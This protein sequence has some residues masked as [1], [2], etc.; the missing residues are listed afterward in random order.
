MQRI[1]LYILFCFTVLQTQGQQQIFQ[2][3]YSDFYFDDF[4]RLPDG[5]FLISGYQSNGPYQTIPLLMKVD[6]IGN[7][8][9][10]KDY[11]DTVTFNFIVDLIAANNNE[12]VMLISVANSYYAG[13]YIFSMRLVKVDSSGNVILRNKFSSTFGINFSKVIQ[14]ENNNFILIGAANKPIGNGADFLIVKLDSNFN[15]LW[16]KQIA[17]KYQSYMLNGCVLSDS[18]YIFQCYAYD[19]IPTPTRSDIVIAKTDTAGNVLWLKQSGNYQTGSGNGI[20]TV[21][22]DSDLL[23]QNGEIFNAFCPNWF[24][25]NFGTDIIIQKIDLNGNEISAHQ[26]GNDWWGSE[27]LKSFALDNNSD[28]IFSTSQLFIKTDNSLNLKWIKRS[29][30]TQQQ[31]ASYNSTIASNGYYI[32]ISNYST[33]SNSFS[34]LI[35]TDTS[36][37]IGCNNLPPIPVGSFFEQPINIG[38]FDVSN[39]ISII[40]ATI[41][42]S[43]YPVLPIT[44]PF[45]SDTIQCLTSTSVSEI[46]KT[47]PDIYLKSNLVDD[48][49]TLIPDKP[50]KNSFEISIYSIQGKLLFKTYSNLNNHVQ[51]NTSYLNKGIYILTIVGNENN[52]NFKF[53]KQ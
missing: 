47:K 8:Q 44:F 45:V 10:I 9:W 46:Q 28:L 41:S 48:N 23:E 52:Y 7:Q 4:V 50:F 37:N 2:R 35:K 6:S 42:D 43:L 1:I 30:S 22:Y 40:P 24:S 13:H 14:A 53:V 20:A 29:H 26:F 38:L 51:I 49:I 39:L 15:V 21:T 25:N 27:I 31:F 16:T 3:I 34:M 33:T 18:N 36:G 19:T 17:Y 32:N 5:G 11:K 12:Y